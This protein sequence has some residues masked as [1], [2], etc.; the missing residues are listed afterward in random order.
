MNEHSGHSDVLPRMN[1]DVKRLYTERLDAYLS[2]NAVFR[3]AE[4]LKA[5]FRSYDGLGAGLRILDAGCGTGTASVA[6]VEALRARGLDY[7]SIDGFDLTRAMLERF[8]EQLQRIDIPGVRLREADV[9]QAESLP[10]SWSGYDL[11]VSAAML[12]YVPRSELPAALRMLGARLA[13]D[14]RLLLFVT[15][16]NLLN[17]ILIEW[18]WNANRYSREELLNAASAADL[19]V[20]GFKRFPLTYFW[21]NLWGNIVEARRKPGA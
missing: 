6:L 8:Q 12:E 1:A 16:K 15:R 17:K 14:G 18:L 9:L 3:Y 10:A 13:P 4:A 21:Q 7:K 2:F 11:I 20:T 5:F 19:Q